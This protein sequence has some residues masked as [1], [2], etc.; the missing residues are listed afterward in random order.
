M[1]DYAY[2]LGPSMRPPS[3]AQRGSRESGYRGP[4]DIGDFTWETLPEI[5]PP[6]T[7]VPP[8]APPPVDINGLVLNGNERVERE[9]NLLPLLALL[10]TLGVLAL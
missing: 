3:L 6:V 2:M 7:L 5:G 10:G 8:P 4:S 9:T 1:I